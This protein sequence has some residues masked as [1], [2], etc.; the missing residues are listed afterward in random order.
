MKDQNSQ[1]A[2]QLWS[3]MNK[4]HFATHMK[5]SNYRAFFRH[6]CI[7]R[8]AYVRMQSKG[9]FKRDVSGLPA[10]RTKKFTVMKKKSRC[11]TAK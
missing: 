1:A 5:R 2:E 7:W 9:K 8:N 3:R 11:R 10:K 4:L 6:Y